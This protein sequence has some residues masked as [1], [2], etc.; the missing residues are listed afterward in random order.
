MEYLLVN[1]GTLEAL[2]K[3]MTFKV[4]KPSDAEEDIDSTG[5]KTS[6]PKDPYNQPCILYVSR[7]A[8]HIRF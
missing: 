8:N 1:V 4:H 3:T 7:Y 5:K 2:R 6:Y